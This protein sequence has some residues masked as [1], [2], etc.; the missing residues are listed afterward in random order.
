MVPPFPS[1]S[2]SKLVTSPSLFRR[3]W[4]THRATCAA[5]ARRTQGVNQWWSMG[6][7]GSYNGG[8]QKWMEAALDSLAAHL[9]TGAC[10][11][12][13]CLIY[14]PRCV[15]DSNTIALIL[16]LDVHLQCL[17]QSSRLAS[18]CAFPLVWKVDS[19][20]Q[21]CTHLSNRDLIACYTGPSIRKHAFTKHGSVCLTLSI[22]NPGFKLRFRGW[23]FVWVCAFD[24]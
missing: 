6:F 9:E 24:L 4:G 14:L 22:T 21:K 12:C 7:P 17:A 18:W 3:P 23:I 13:V 2:T 8:T 15:C 19:G 20:V 10:A 5:S 11:A 16:C 1:L